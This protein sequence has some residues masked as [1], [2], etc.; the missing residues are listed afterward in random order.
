M[1][2]T[3]DECDKYLLSWLLWEYKPLAGSIGG[4]CTGCSYGAFYPNARKFK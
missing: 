2:D 4:T 3:L 1:Y